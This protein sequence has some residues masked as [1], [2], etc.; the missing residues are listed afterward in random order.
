M[1]HPQVS[2][3]IPAFNRAET[4]GNAIASVQA[5]TFQDF[6]LII[7]DDGSRD[8]A[9]LESIVAELHD[10][11]VRLVCHAVNKGVSAARNTGI[12]AARGRFVA[13]L[14]SDDLWLPAKLETQVTAALRSEDPSRV[15]CLAKTRIVMPGGWERVRPLAWPAPGATFSAFLYG[16][17]G[18]AQCSS[19]FLA[20]GLARSVSFNE[21][22]RQY[23]DHLFLIEAQRQGGQFLMLDEVLSVWMNDERPDRLSFDETE[24]RVALFAE[25][26]KGAIPAPV[27]RAFE[28]RTT[29]ELIWKHSRRRAL[30]K[31]ARA[32]AGGGMAP[33][34]AFILF[35]RMVIPHARYQRLRKRF[36]AA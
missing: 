11:R 3:I 21:Q 9:T 26:A 31:L 34:Q 30:S 25:L 23:E 29:C 5:Q 13:F 35:A 12:A 33:R 10:A 32:V 4:I 16:E 27:L 15:V 2:V 24:A 7:V 19:F 1:N 28:A 20:T 8:V 14:D 18:F 22:L 36:T 6:E 17:G